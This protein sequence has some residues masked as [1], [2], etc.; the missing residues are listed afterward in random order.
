MTIIIIRT[1]Y[2]KTPIITC[3]CNNYYFL[4]RQPCSVQV[5][6]HKPQISHARD[7]TQTLNF[8]STW[9][10]TS[11]TVLISRHFYRHRYWMALLHLAATTDLNITPARLD[12]YVVSVVRLAKQWVTMSEWVSDYSTQTLLRHTLTNPTPF[13]CV[14]RYV[15]RQA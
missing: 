3:R 6:S 7:V 10:H 4:T 12:H 2:F 15:H 11:T 14:H 5:T 1:Q 9:R 8:P 13:T